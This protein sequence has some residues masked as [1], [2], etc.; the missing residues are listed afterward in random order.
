MRRSESTV[1]RAPFVILLL[2]LTLTPGCLFFPRKHTPQA[3]RAKGGTGAVRGQVL[4]MDTRQPATGT[5]ISLLGDTTV[6]VTD[7]E[8][9][10]S[11]PAVAAGWQTVVARKES[12]VTCG[13]TLDL[14]SGT[15][16]EVTFLLQPLDGHL[17][18]ASS[19]V[20]NLCGSC[21]VLHQQ[22]TLLGGSANAPCLTCH[23]ANYP[24]MSNQA[25]YEQTLHSAAVVADNPSP[26]ELSLG[27][28]ERGECVNCHEPHGINNSHRHL[29]T[30]AA[31][32][33][34]NPL[35]YSCHQ[36]PGSG[37]TRDYPGQAVCEATD[38]VHL[39]PS[40]TRQD[41]LPIYPGSEAEV[42]ECYNCHNPHGATK[43]GTPGG[44]VTTAMTRDEEG[45]LCVKCHTYWSGRPVET[46]K[47]AC[48]LCHNPHQVRKNGIL[49]IKKPGV[50][51]GELVDVTTYYG[52]HRLVGNLLT[53]AYCLGCHNN[54]A[55]NYY[56][57]RAKVPDVANTQFKNVTTGALPNANYR[58]LHK[59]HVYGPI[60]DDDGL[61]SVG[62]YYAGTGTKRN[63]YP[64]GYHES[65][66]GVP[67][68]AENK[69]WCIDCH[70]VHP[71]GDTSD[72]RRGRLLK[73]GLVQRATVTSNPTH[74]I[75]YNDKA[76]CSMNPISPCHRGQDRNNRYTGCDWCHTA[77]GSPGYACDCTDKTCAPFWTVAGPPLECGGTE[78]GTPG[79]THGANH[80][81]ATRI[82]PRRPVQL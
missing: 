22:P 4:Y 26:V 32:T 36:K 69:V 19:R 13:E 72:N 44:Q 12:F 70:D 45:I 59:V 71:H 1:W 67:K 48:S 42:G 35:C 37:H 18:G 15:A 40:S 3:D 9:R 54:N 21:H 60:G 79:F 46:T 17:H 30:V 57:G 41:L 2:S 29:L 52:T 82:A 64:G 25:I 28:K 66:G 53:N 61:V 55:G 50:G 8:G 65:W 33:S 62:S 11:L 75:G 6:V 14:R 78:E 47:H 31:P 63:C 51:T 74:G 81:D 56:R 34:S 77:P 10:F 5:A 76:G 80:Y 27:G 43:D 7:A 58:D 39:N 49:Q 20:P 38:N 24:R 16:S 23:Q 73:T 68:T